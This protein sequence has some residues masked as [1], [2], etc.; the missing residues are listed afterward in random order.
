MIM[1]LLLAASVLQMPDRVSVFVPAK[2]DKGGSI[3][4][5]QDLA[6]VY[7]A[8]LAVAASQGVVTFSNKADGVISVNIGGSKQQG[9]QARLSIQVMA[10]EMPSDQPPQTRVELT[11]QGFQWGLRGWGDG[12]ATKKYFDALTEKLVTTP[13]LTAAQR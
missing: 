12:K 7:T 3:V 9:R 8:A 6:T 2:D 13:R 10:L 11:T 4:Y 1:T 5:R